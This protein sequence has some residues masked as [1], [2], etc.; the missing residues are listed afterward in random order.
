M[1]RHLCLLNLHAM[2][3]LI[4]GENGNSKSLQDTLRPLDKFSR[5]PAHKLAKAEECVSAVLQG[6]PACT[7][8]VNVCAVHFA[9][10]LLE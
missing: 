9:G 2:L 3:H 10:F 5:L 1:D 6:W 4:T 7:A 8:V